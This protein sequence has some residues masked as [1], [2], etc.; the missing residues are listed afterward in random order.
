[1]SHANPSGDLSVVVERALDLLIDKLEARRFG[2]TKRPRQSPTTFAAATPSAHATGVES[3][4]SGLVDLTSRAAVARSPKQGPNL[5]R[6]KSKSRPSK[7]SGG[8]RASR[9]RVGRPNISSEA[10]REV[11]N[12]DGVRCSFVAI[13]GCRCSARAFLEFDHRNPIGLGGA[14]TPGNLRMLCRA[15]N[16]LA[17]E[18]AYGKDH[19]QAAIERKRSR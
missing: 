17:A 10:R 15:H 19:V 14:N 18:L 8:S 7:T 9:S 13:D 5:H 3:A 1:M 16:Q 4:D 11:L 12:R 2:A 6:S